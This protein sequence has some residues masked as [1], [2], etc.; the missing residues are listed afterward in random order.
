MTH[1][2]WTN[3]SL[4]GGGSQCWCWCQQWD[5]WLG[6]RSGGGRD[7]ECCS[8]GLRRVVDRDLRCR[9]VDWDLCGVGGVGFV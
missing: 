7:D 4:G 2:Y 6:N 5:W 1:S 3:H 8:G 9:V